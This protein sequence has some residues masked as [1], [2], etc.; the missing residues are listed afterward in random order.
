MTFYK[1]PICRSRHLSTT[2]LLVR[3]AKPICGQWTASAFP[4]RRLFGLK[5][6]SY[7]SYKVIAPPVLVAA[8]G[9]S[10]KVTTAYGSWHVKQPIKHPTVLSLTTSMSRIFCLLKMLASHEA[11]AEWVNYYILYSF[12]SHRTLSQYRMI[13][14]SLHSSTNPSIANP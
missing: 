8:M 7:L 14:K 5:A 1:T 3:A 2:R 11:L 13:C 12:R 4:P 10:Q 6:P 9:G